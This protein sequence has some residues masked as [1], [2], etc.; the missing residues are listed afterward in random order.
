MKHPASLSR[1]LPML[2]WASRYHTAQLTADG[3][4]ALIVAI[5]LIPQAMAYALLAGMPAETGLYASIC[6]LTL[7]CLLGTSSTLSVAPVAVVSLMTG[8]ALARLDLSTTADY[9]AAAV[10]LAALVGLLSLGMGL[11]RLGFLANFISQPVISAFITASAVIIAISQL[12]TLFGI[13]V[14]GRTPLQRLPALL[15][16]LPDTNLLTLWFGVASIAAILW[17][18]TGLGAWLV[19]RGVPLVVA[20]TVSRSG[21]LLVVV[22]AALL[23]FGFGV[24]RF[25]VALLGSIPKG[26]PTLALPQFTIEQLRGLWSSAVLVCLIGFVESVSMARVMAAK[27]RERIDLDQ[28]LVALGAA[29]LAAA[30]GGG[31]PVSGGFSRS[32]VNFEAGAATPAAGLFTA[33]LMAVVV[34]LLTPLLFWIPRVSLAAIILVA[35]YSLLDFSV[36]TRSWRYSRSDFVAVVSTL[37]LTL[38]LGVESGLAAGVL[39]SLLMHLY[40][41]LR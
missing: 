35:V 4:A 5:V 18:R 2:A 36:L 38:T 23:A 14:S 7:Y 13:D 37:L 1:W 19:A 40:R 20:T 34:W 32:M 15:Q 6:G 30:A 16:A 10:A 17:C 3:M 8:A 21:P 25:G 12:G 24:D 41:N 22:M 33:I 29:N 9:L 26:L 31:F 11:L 39:V 28:E 27:R